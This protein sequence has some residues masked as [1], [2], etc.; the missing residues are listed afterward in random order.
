M[1]DPDITAIR[2]GRPV[3]ARPKDEPTGSLDPTSSKVV[4]QGAP[5]G[6]AGRKRKDVPAATSGPLPPIA[7][8]AVIPPP[9]GGKLKHKVQ[10]TSRLS[11]QK[12]VGPGTGP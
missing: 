1:T 12:T 3:A 10:E 5:P 11:A 8:P 9:Q 6:Y 7:P 4:S 2:E